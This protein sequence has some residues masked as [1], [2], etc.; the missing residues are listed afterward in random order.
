MGPTC[1]RY[2]SV[3]ERIGVMAEPEITER[4][5]TANSRYIV[6]CSVGLYYEL[7]PA[8]GFNS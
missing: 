6:L 1:A 3:A 4:E 7:T 5:L 2:V 8:P